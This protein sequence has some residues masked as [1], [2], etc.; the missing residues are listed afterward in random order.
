M[1]FNAKPLILFENLFGKGV[2][3]ATDTDADSQFSVDNLIN[4]VVYQ[5][6]KG[7]TAPLIN[8][9]LNGDFETGDFT[10]YTA[11][12]STI[13]T[14]NPATGTYCA[15]L[16]AAGSDVDGAETDKIDV[17]ITRPWR[18]KAKVDVDAYSNGFYIL[19]LVFYTA[20]DALISS[21]SIDFWDATTSGY[22]QVNEL[23]QEFF[24]SNTAKVAIQAVWVAT[25][26][27][28][29]FIDDIEFY[30][31]PGDHLVTV[32]LNKTLNGGAETGD[33]SNW[34]L[35]D[36][37][38]ESTNPNSGTYSFEL[39]AAGSDVDG[40]ESAKVT[41]D[42]TK[43]WRLKVQHEVT[44]RSGGIYYSKLHFYDS[45]DNLISTTTLQT[46]SAVTGAYVEVSKQLG[47]GG[48]IEFPAGTVTVAVQDAW[49]GTPT[50]TAYMDDFILYEEFD[51]D[52][53]GIAN[54][55][56]WS[57]NADVSLESSVDNTEVIS[58]WTERLAAF[59]PPD[60]TIIIE[61]F[62]AVG[63]PQRAWRLRIVALNL[64]PFAGDL[65]LGARMEFP[66][67]V[68]GPFGPK[69]RKVAGQLAKNQFGQF[70][71]RTVI[72]REGQITMTFRRL[73]TDF[74]E[75]TLRPAFEDHLISGTFYVSWD[76]DQH[77][78]QKFIGYMPDGAELNPMYEG[79]LLSVTLRF[80]PMPVA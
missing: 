67:W 27:G 65:K 26:T 39:V 68:Q 66:N 8:K 44:A 76:A 21:K 74:I 6:W 13:D 20:G 50:G 31:D 78:D 58:S 46:W 24:P 9:V 45:G 77:E 33:G 70:I 53:M 49:D 10:G 1:S 11:N 51:P 16:V 79:R 3:S 17:D 19:S 55:N 63:T 34:T 52:T 37:T 47:P 12:A 56:F 2:L 71:Q 22:E 7:A 61:P 35:N 38:V 23:V 28:T 57:A 15:K 25:P 14:T 5:L 32:D 29:A 18:L 64:A 60:D 73:T 30:E 80:M 69:P 48:D 42:T 40:A 72:R 62:T 75:N 59:T 36:G 4:Q 54:H 41:I 43:L